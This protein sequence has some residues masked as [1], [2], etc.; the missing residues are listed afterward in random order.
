MGRKKKTDLKA[1]DIVTSPLKEW[2]PGDAQFVI[3]EDMVRL[4]EAITEKLAFIDG[5]KLVKK[6]PVTLEIPVEESRKRRITNIIAPTRLN[7][8]SLVKIAKA[9]EVD[10]TCVRKEAWSY[11]C[12]IEI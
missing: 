2:T 3:R 11:L 9:L 7:L 4:Q 8:T 10:F 6:S 5:V 12:K 1:A